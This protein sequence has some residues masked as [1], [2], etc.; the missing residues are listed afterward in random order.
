MPRSA[1]FGVLFGS[2][3]RSPLPDNSWTDPTDPAKERRYDGSSKVSSGVWGNGAA[4][5]GSAG[6]FH[7]LIRQRAGGGGAQSVAAAAGRDGQR[8]HH[9]G[10][11]HT[12]FP[13]AVLVD[14]TG[15]VLEQLRGPAVRPISHPSSAAGR[16]S[17]A[18][19]AR[20]AAPAATSTVTS[21]QAA[22]GPCG[23]GGT[24]TPSTP[25]PTVT[26]GP[27][28]T[29]SPVPATATPVVATNL[30]LGKAVKVSSEDPAHP[31]PMAV[32]GDPATWWASLP[33][34]GPLLLGAEQAVDSRSTWARHRWC[35]RCT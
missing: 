21:L 20:A 11:R 35:S 29:A 10:R 4:D 18:R 33:G 22:F 13:D 30:A 26:T 12:C 24:A 2:T 7:C 16:M 6:W 27:S 28:P 14:C 31:G 25:Q 19:G 23:Q 1:R 17:V 9:L 8:H 5:R 3:V 32:D 34:R 15:A